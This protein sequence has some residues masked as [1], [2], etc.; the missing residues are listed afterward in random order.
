MLAF[1]AAPVDNLIGL[2]RRLI[3]RS[4]GLPIHY[5]IARLHA[6]H[7][8]LQK[9]ATKHSE[10]ALEQTE[11]SVAQALRDGMS[12]GVQEAMRLVDELRRELAID[13]ARQA[14]S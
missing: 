2:L 12:L 13:A 1:P 10:Q 14:R 11:G 6:V 8:N 4:S 9:R 5:V 7:D 3:G